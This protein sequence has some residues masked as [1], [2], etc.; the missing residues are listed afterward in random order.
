MLPYLEEGGAG[1]RS[2][3]AEAVSAAR[4]LIA[5]YDIGLHEPQYPVL[6]A[7][8]GSIPEDAFIV[9]DVTP[10]LRCTLRR[11]AYQKPTR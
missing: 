5:Y 9:W 8:Q 1:D 6:E 11:L 4:S 2:S 7:I 10:M 3:P